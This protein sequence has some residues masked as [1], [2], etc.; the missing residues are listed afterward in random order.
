MLDTTSKVDSCADLALRKKVRPTARPQARPAKAP[1]GRDDSG[2]P[3]ETCSSLKDQLPG[4]TSNFNTTETPTPPTKTSPSRPSRR[5]VTI[6]RM[7]KTEEDKPPS[8]LLLFLLG[9]SPC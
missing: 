8:G 3:S 1:R 6:G 5:T 9:V 7:N 2:S 4:A